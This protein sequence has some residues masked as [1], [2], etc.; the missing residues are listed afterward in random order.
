MTE[1]KIS[2]DKA[3]HEA[4]IMRADLRSLISG[5]AHQDTIDRKV[6]QMERLEKRAGWGVF[7]WL[8]QNEDFS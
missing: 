2:R 8:E 6:A 7:N 5:G 1:Q 3:I 4:K